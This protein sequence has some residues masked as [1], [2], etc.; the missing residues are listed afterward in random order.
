MRVATI[1][2]IIQNSAWNLIRAIRQ[3]KEIKGTWLGKE[4]VKLSLF[5]DNTTQY[6]KDSKNS[7]STLIPLKHFQQSSREQNQHIKH[8]NFSTHQQWTHWRRH[9]ESN[10]IHSS[11]KRKEEKEKHRNTLKGC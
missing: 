10:P 4:E 8:S 5:A 3:E 2:T 11:F 7:T 6:S 9:Q 1:T